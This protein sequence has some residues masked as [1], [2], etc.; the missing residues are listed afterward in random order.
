MLRYLSLRLPLLVA[1]AALAALV[2]AGTAQAVH[3]RPF[4]ATPKRDSLVVSYAP[5]GGGGPPAHIAPFAFASCPPVPTSPFLTVSTADS[6]ALPPTFVGSST[7]TVCPVPGCVAPD[8]RA[9]IS[10]VGVRCGPAGPGSFPGA[11][12]GGLNGSYTGSVAVNYPLRI[13]DHCN[14]GGGPPPPGCA[15]GGV[16]ASTAT[17][18]DF[19]FPIVVG[20][21]PGAP[22]TP[23][24]PGSTCAVVT[25]FNT[26]LPGAIPAAGSGLPRMN[27]QMGP[28][29][30]DDGG[31]D[32]SGATPG[33]A[34]FV[35]QGVFVP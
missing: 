23:A 3:T 30:V 10:L 31:P 16:P 27:I 26:V 5:C 18:V 11:C 32:A 17:V 25:T 28:V 33:N 4:A 9:S 22:P 1:V 12:P 15:P 34:P 29:T 2:L 8:I 21:A 14:M 7:L 35:Q 24:G 19:T 20:C 13:T 6:N